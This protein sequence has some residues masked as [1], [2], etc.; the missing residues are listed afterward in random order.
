MKPTSCTN[1]ILAPDSHVP[2]F[3][4]AQLTI[5]ERETGLSVGD[6]IVSLARTEAREAS[7]LFRSHAPK[8]SVKRLLYPL[9]NILQD[10]GMYARNVSANLLDAG[11][12]VRLF[13]VAHG[14]SFQ[15]VC[16]TSFLQTR[17]IE[18]AAK[19]KGMIQASGLSLAR[20]DAKLKSTS[21]YIF[22][23]HVCHVQFVS[24][25]VRAGML[26][27]AAFRLACIVAHVETQI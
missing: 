1:T 9:Q 19:R 10:L 4:Q 11:Q 18:F 7:L 2:D 16:V 17:V 3:R 8:E 6:G 24:G 20:I 14:L 25:L 23:S 13:D 5:R 15:P 12:L 27:V 21:C 26:L 22:I